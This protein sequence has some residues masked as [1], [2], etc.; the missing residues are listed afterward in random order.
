MTLLVETDSACERSEYPRLAM[1][2]YLCERTFTGWCFTVPDG[3]LPP[4]FVRRMLVR[5]ENGSII[6]ATDSKYFGSD[7]QESVFFAWQ[8]AIAADLEKGLAE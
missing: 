2:M 1:I 6:M 4:G 7:E 8:A 5:K 3:D